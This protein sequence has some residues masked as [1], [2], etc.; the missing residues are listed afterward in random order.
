AGP[1]EV[2]LSGYANGNRPLPLRTVLEPN[3]AAILLE[4]PL[5]GGMPQLFFRSVPGEP[6]R[7]HRD[8]VYSLPV[9]ESRFELGQGFHGGFSHQDAANRYAVDL[10]VPEGTPVYAARAGRVIQTRSG[11]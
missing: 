7:V 5:A 6:N 4:V 2:E 10:I 8:V 9:E 1:V 11:H 3:R